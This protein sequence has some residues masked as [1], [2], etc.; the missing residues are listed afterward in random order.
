[1]CGR[2][3][4]SKKEADLEKRF[5]AKFYSDEIDRYN[6]LPLFNIGPSM[7]VPV[8]L[9]HEPERIQWVKWG[10]VPSWAKDAKASPPQINARIESVLEKPYFREAIQKRR[11]LV[12][13]DGYFEWKAVN[14]TTKIPYYIHL[15]QTELFAVAGIWEEWN[16]QKAFSLITQHPNEALLTVHDRMPAILLP[17]QEKAYLESKTGEE[18]ISMI[19]PYS[20]GK[21]AFHTVSK[22]LN[23]SFD[24]DP[25]LLLPSSHDDVAVQGSLF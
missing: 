13:L 1:M 19:R 24:N 5:G 3:S 15:Q 14:K 9:D 21:M 25:T 4:L 6:P 17:N 11:C 23:S 10:F 18:A 7:S 16:N 2:S 20:Q 22:R 12:L 8:I